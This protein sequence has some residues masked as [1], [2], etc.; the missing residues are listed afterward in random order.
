VP[1]VI[2]CRPKKRAPAPRAATI[3][4]PIPASQGSPTPRAAYTKQS[5]E[6]ECADHECRELQGETG[7]GIIP[8]PGL[9]IWSI[10]NTSP[11][12]WVCL[13]AHRELTTDRVPGRQ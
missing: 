5:C 3:T 10:A 1:C 13:A 12:V 9:H 7:D 11:S 4:L 8:L 6:N 2:R